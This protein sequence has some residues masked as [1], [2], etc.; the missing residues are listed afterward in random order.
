[1]TRRIVILSDL[2]MAAPGGP[3]SDPFAVDDVFAALL[4]RIGRDGAPARLILLGDTFDLVL[5]AGALAGRARRDPVA[6]ALGALDAIAEAHPRVL[7]SLA[8][9]AAAGHAVDLVP[10]NHDIELLRPAVQQRLRHLVAR[11]GGDGVPA[12]RV[13]FPPWVVHVPGVLYAEHG[14]QHHDLN[15]F[16]GL[17]ARTATPGHPPV[18][19]PVALCLD[20]GRVELARRRVP[21]A[22]RGGGALYAGALAAQLARASVCLALGEGRRAGANHARMV[23]ELAA[24]LG[25]PVAALLEIQRA[26]A[27]TPA[28][29]VHRLA[30]GGDFMLGAA[31]RVS[32]ALANAGAGTAFCVFGHTHRADDRP[33]SEGADAPRYL[34]AGTWST[35]VRPGREACEDRLRYIH[36]EYGDDRPATAHLR[37]AGAPDRLE[38]SPRPTAVA[39]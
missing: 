31:H 35:L 6:A 9:F 19:R 11:S 39:A 36:I 37:R 5:A 2:H 20:E 1:V 14:Q 25:L 23:H 34:N 7:G 33:L 4:A 21:G 22:R 8:A 16:R 29:L 12:D 15:H 18:S 3:L 32:D 27:P 13:A 10:G 38:G 17:L 30:A 28:G 24:E 26:A